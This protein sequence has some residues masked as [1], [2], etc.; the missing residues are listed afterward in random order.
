MKFRLCA[1][2]QV[3]DAQNKFEEASAYGRTNYSRFDILPDAQTDTILV[4]LEIE[5]V[6]QEVH[7]KVGE[8]GDQAVKMI[9]APNKSSLVDTKP[10]DSMWSAKA[11][12]D[13]NA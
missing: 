3:R 9:R 10:I 2:D 11:L 1:A 8:Q 6:T 12:G 5:E 13:M 4:A 7:A